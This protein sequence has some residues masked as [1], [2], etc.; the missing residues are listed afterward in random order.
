M[1]NSSKSSCIF[2]KVDYEK[3]YDSLI[4]ILFIICYRDLVFVESG[5]NG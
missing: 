5:L 2:F 3:V 4:G 1:A